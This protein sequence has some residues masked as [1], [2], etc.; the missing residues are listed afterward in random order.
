MNTFAEILDQAKTIAVVGISDKP[1]RTSYAISRYLLGVG[2]TVAPVNP[3]LDEVHG[4]KSYPDLQSVPAS[5][6][7]DIVNIFRRP[8]YTADVVRDVIERMK[9]TDEHPVIWTQIGVSSREAEELAESAGLTY[10]KNRCIMVEHS[11][12]G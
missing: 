7:I 8:D 6:Q 9:T 2:F 12:Q 11:R 5:T 4:M 1:A 10:V 3:H